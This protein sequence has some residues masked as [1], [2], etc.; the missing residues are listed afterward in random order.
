MR[1]LASDF[2]LSKTVET[3]SVGCEDV[4]KDEDSFS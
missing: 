1:R 2:G 3:H 4:T